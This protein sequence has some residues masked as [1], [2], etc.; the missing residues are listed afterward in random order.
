VKAAQFARSCDRSW[1]AACAAFPRIAPD[2]PLTGDELKQ[3]SAILRR[4]G[5]VGRDVIIAAPGEKLQSG[6]IELPAKAAGV[7]MDELARAEFGRVQKLDVSAAELSWWEL[8]ASSRAGK[9]TVVMAVAYPHADA[10]PVAQSYEEAGFR[11]C[12][13]DTPTSAVARGCLPLMHGKRAFGALDIGA[14]AGVLVLV[15]DGVVV[16]ERRIPEAGIAKLAGVLESCLGAGREAAEHVIR[17]VGLTPGA[18]AG[19]EDRFGEARGLIAR[20]VEAAL[21]EV[22]RTLAYASHQYSD[23]AVETLLLCG[24]GACMPG[25]R[26]YVAARV[27]TD[28]RLATFDQGVQCDEEVRRRAGIY[29]ACAVGLAR[30]S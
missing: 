21:A 25:L 27:E 18:D 24:G 5:F 16:Y 17:E 12:G 6:I 26:D 8:P 14:T 2:A 23:A 30:F 10:E 3:I 19:S 29:P 22:Q 4:Q 11:V 15:R 9:G 7:P 1:L 13:V 20:H 28:V